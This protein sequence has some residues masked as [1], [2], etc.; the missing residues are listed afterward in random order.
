MLKY[1]VEGSGKVSICLFHGYKG[2]SDSLRVL[3]AGLKEFRRIYFEAPYFVTNNS[4]AWI[5]ESREADLSEVIDDL[6]RILRLELRVD[7]DRDLF[8]GFSQG[9]Q[10]LHRAL[11]IIPFKNL[12]FLCPRFDVFSPQNQIKRFFCYLSKNDPKVSFF[13]AFNGF[14]LI[15]SFSETSV[16]VIG[17]SKHKVSAYGLKT[18]HYWLKE[19]TL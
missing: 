4:Y 16:L 12:I 17:V 19:Y 7:L 13:E 10:F 6:W 5:P 15:S 9:A 8:L 1:L 2:N 18:L 3:G 11:N 14:Q